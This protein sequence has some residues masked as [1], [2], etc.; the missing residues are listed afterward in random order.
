MEYW[1]WENAGYGYWSWGSLAGREVY[2]GLDGAKAAA[3]ADYESRIFSALSTPPAAAE[4]S[5]ARYWKFRE[6]V[7]NLVFDPIQR[8]GRVEAEILSQLERITTEYSEMVKAP[9]QEA[10]E[11]NASVEARLMEALTE[12]DALRS[13]NTKLVLAERDRLE[14]SLSAAGIKP[15]PSSPTAERREIVARRAAAIWQD[16]LDKDD[17]TS[18]DEYPDMALITFDELN[19]AILAALDGGAGE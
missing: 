9:S 8:G 2:G 14:A 11:S 18:P 6:K 10:V 4:S 15:G 5:D 3:Q 16:L 17:R 13:A 1:A 7:E 19:D 12:N